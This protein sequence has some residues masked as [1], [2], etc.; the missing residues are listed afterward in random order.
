MTENNFLN[1]EETTGVTETEATESV[2]TETTT[3]YVTPEMYGAV[4]DGV[5]D[6]TAALQSAFNTGKNVIFLNDY[7]IT[8]RITILNMSGFKVYGNNHTINVSSKEP[9]SSD[10]LVKEAFY[11]Y[12]CSNISFEDL[13]IVSVADQNLI[14]ENEVFTSGLKS[15]NVRGFKIWL[16][17]NISIENYTSDKLHTDI[18]LA[19][20]DNIR[21]NNW[22]SNNCLNG[23]Y[24]R[25]VNNAYISNFRIVCDPQNTVEDFYGFHFD[26]STENIYVRDGE[27]IF[28]NAYES[29]VCERDGVTSTANLRA[30]LLTI[31]GGTT[32]KY[33]KQIFVD[34]VKF[35]AQN[36]LNINTVEDAPVFS[37]CTFTAY[38]PSGAV[39]QTKGHLTL[40]DSAT[41]NNCA[42]YLGDLSPA[43]VSENDI[44]ITLNSCELYQS[45]VTGSTNNP[46][47]LGYGGN[48]K[49]IDSY[50]N[51]PGDI[52]KLTSDAGTEFYNCVINMASSD[53]AVVVFEVSAMTHDTYFVK[54]FVNNGYYVNWSALTDSSNLNVIGSNLI[55]GNTGWYHGTKPTTMGTAKLYNSYFNDTKITL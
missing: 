53:S 22:N 40:T 5:T 35:T 37:N 15:S 52:R 54:S 7:Y 16:S 3:D 44:T 31:H 11:V 8:S 42:F 4:G 49:L 19:G 38:Y 9:T 24:T 6:D 14:G 26:V 12:R 17:D 21:I 50:I 1:Y 13:S 20:C 51:W 27:A 18:F 47:L 23:L 55:S 30:P 29:V 2:T 32:D 41:F 36:I 25:V 46:Y 33:Q 45:T 43:F 34:N 48:Y 39:D 10:N 28:E